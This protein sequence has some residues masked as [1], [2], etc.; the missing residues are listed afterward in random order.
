MFR[1]IL[2]ALCVASVACSPVY[3]MPEGQEAGARMIEGSPEALGVLALL[4]DGSTTEDLLDIDVAL[5]ARAARSLVSHRNGPDG[6]FG[7]ADDDD[8]DSID[9]ADG[10]Y[11]VGNSALAA[12]EA[13]ATDNG[14]VALNP[15]DVLGTWDGV[16]FTVA[17]AEATVELA[18]TGGA[19]WLDD[20]IGLNSRA[21]DSIVAARPIQ[22]VAEL[23]SL[24]YVGNSALTDL[25][26]AAAGEP[27][28]DVPGW[29]IVYIYA[30][31]AG[32]GWRDQ[33]P[34]GLADMID[35]AL[36]RDDWCG[37]AFG[38]P[39]L[40]KAQIDRFNCED[41]GYVVE[42]GQLVDEYHGLEWYIEFEMNNLDFEYPYAVCEI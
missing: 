8:F 10:C 19:G 2:P 34:A 1:S 25:K 22:T 12:L 40:V 29:D 23:A 42:L 32:E 21:V 30:D 24:Y 38:Q 35:G 33:V 9:E 17:E 28:C 16:T 26:E 13:Y 7:T 36:E 6:V 4:N 3:L 18:N 31:E 27:A 41:K 37:E 39:W 5:D 20:E 15:D 14:W 11:Y